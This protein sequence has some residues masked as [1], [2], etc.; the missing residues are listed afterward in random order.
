MDSSIRRTLWGA[1][2]AL[3]LLAA[4]GLVLTLTVLQMGKRQ[5]YR[6]VQGSEPLIDA[7][8][9]MDEDT[10]TILAAARGYHLTRNTEFEQQYDDAVRE[11]EKASANA[12]QL[13]TDARDLQIV[14]ALRRH[15]TDIKGLTAAEIQATKDGKLDN[16][17]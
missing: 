11:F 8:R 4:I 14:S 17:S 1:F 2:A 13:A 7:V 3:G 10:T 9:T 16:A 6:I 12:G 15:F 5:E